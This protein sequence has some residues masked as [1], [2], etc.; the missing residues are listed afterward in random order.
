MTA[1]IAGSSRTPSDLTRRTALALLGAGA[2]GAVAAP[3]WG[4]DGRRPATMSSP[5][6]TPWDR[7]VLAKVDVGNALDHLHHL[8]ERIGQRYSGTPAEGRAA[9]YLAGVLDDYGYDVETPSFAVPDRYL[10][11]IRSPA[12]DDTLCWGVGAASAGAMDAQVSGPLLVAPSADPRDLPADLGGAVVLRAIDVAD[13]SLTTFAQVAQER[14]AGALIW[15]RIDGIAPRQSSTF[16]PA[17]VAGATPVTIPVVGVGQVQKHALLASAAAGPVTL[18]VTTTHHRSLTSS[19][20]I[21]TRRGTGMPGRVRPKVM[22]CAHYDSVIGAKGA[23]DDGSGTVLTLELARALRRV[24]VEADLQFALWGSEEV[25]LVGSRNYVASLDD[26]ARAGIRGVF[27]NDMVGTSW[28]PAERYWV[29]SYDGQPNV[30]NAEVLAA[31]RRLGY[32]A[33]M[34]D[35]TQRGSSDHQS[36]QEVG[37]PSGNFTWRAAESPALLEPPYHS[38]DDTIARNI[39]PERLA[40]SI[41]IIGCATFALARG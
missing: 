5:R 4:V 8:T 28:D 23:N 18:D 13:E 33:R 41:E 25:G 2:A 10:G 24:P 6:L 9:R 11:E 3:A 30:V 1:R 15:T 14:G 16:V 21:G 22:V 12:L 26:D 39:S 7:Q 35:V 37:V 36:F 34:S 29:L 40:V 38:S 27:N 17:L 31:G 20:V 32:D 19:N